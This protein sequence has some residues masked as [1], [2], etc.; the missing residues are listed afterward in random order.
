MGLSLDIRVLTERPGELLGN[1]K[2]SKGD[3]LGLQFLSNVREILIQVE[4][5]FFPLLSTENLG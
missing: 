3:A 5:D 1:D 2:L 4:N